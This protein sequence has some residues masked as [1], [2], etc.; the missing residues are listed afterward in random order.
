MYKII[1]LTLFS[2]SAIATTIKECHHY[3]DQ[4]NTYINIFHQTTHKYINKRTVA[5][6][7][8]KSYQ[9]SLLSECKGK[10]NLLHYQSQKNEVNRL[11]KEYN[12]K[13]TL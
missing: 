8:I 9:D 10:V 11:L 6:R 1:F 4:Y 13:T 12:A 5:I 2:V 7:M 3:E